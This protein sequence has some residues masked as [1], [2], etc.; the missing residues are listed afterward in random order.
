MLNISLG[1][2]HALPCIRAKLIA[3]ERVF[4]KGFVRGREVESALL[5]KHIFLF[6]HNKLILIKCLKSER[7]L[8]ANGSLSHV[9]YHRI[10]LVSTSVDAVLFNG[11]QHLI[12]KFNASA[13]S[14]ADS[15]HLPEELLIKVDGER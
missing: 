5:I 9:V 3:S 12:I 8:A 4:D 14:E 7:L 10:K 1:P 15:P 13:P 2:L 11:G 6:F